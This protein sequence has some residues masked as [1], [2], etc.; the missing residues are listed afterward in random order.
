[1]LKGWKAGSVRLTLEIV[2]SRHQSPFLMN[3]SQGMEE[4]MGEHAQVG[5]FRSNEYSIPKFLPPLDRSVAKSSFPLT[6]V[7]IPGLAQ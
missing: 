4:I 5:I 1:M 2:Q 3:S 6:P 7:S